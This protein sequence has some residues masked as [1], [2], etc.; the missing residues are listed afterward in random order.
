M[1]DHLSTYD[2]STSRPRKARF[3]KLSI[4]Y[5]HFEH[6]PPWSIRAPRSYPIA[7]SVFASFNGPSHSI[8]SPI[9]PARSQNRS[10][11]ATVGDAIERRSDIGLAFSES[12]DS[13]ADKN[14]FFVSVPI[15]RKPERV[16]AELRRRIRVWPA[17]QSTPRLYGSRS[18]AMASV[19]DFPRKPNSTKLR[20]SGVLAASPFALESDMC[21]WGISSGIAI[22]T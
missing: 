21:R 10:F 18:I 5:A 22:P 3:A 9:E 14:L 15:L 8:Q 16:E 12:N 13:L 2:V 1:L 7:R 17:W 19:K 4:S 11:R 20:S 6:H